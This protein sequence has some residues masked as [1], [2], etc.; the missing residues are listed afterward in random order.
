L[1]PIL[2]EDGTLALCPGSDPANIFDKAEE[3][4]QRRYVLED[5]ND[6]A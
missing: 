4:S 3:W 5:T 6:L 2:N 1:I